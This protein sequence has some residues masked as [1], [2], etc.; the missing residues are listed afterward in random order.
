MADTRPTARSVLPRPATIFGAALLAV[1]AW[2]ALFALARAAP[3]LALAF[4][5]ALLGSVF[6]LAIRHLSPP[7]PRA[8]ATFLVLGAVIGLVLGTAWLALPTVLA[9]GRDLLARLPEI[10]EA[11]IAAVRKPFASRG[12]AGEGPGALT[13]AIR[14]ELTHRLTAA[15]GSALPLA[16]AAVTGLF[17]VFAT[18]TVAGFLAYRPDVYVDGFLRL[19]PPRRRPDFALFVARLGALVQQWML[20]ALISMTVVG[21]LTAIGLRA[22]G[23]GP[24]FALATVMFFAEFVP[25]LG[26]IFAGLAAGTVALADSPEKA[27]W[28]AALYVGV[29]QLESNLVTPLVMKRV[30]QLQPALLLVWQL[31]LGVLFGFPGVIVATPLLACVQLAVQHFYLEPREALAERPPPAGPGQGNGSGTTSGPSSGSPTPRPFGS[32]G[33][34]PGASGSTGSSG[35]GGAPGAGGGANTP[36]GLSGGGPTTSTRDA[37]ASPPPVES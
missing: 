27:V 7:L 12:L 25:Y 23:V 22:I 33:S 29:Q 1:L 35:R 15:L 21:V 14:G 16:Q 3:I 2:S 17:G 19:V 11:A 9:Q 34:S 4:L 36:A 5:A 18:L 20:G 28:V 13:A 26:P 32:S 30:V 31:G 8:L 37:R 24:W 6:A 10:L